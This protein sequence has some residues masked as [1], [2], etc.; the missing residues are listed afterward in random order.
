LGYTSGHNTISSTGLAPTTAW[1]SNQF[2][3]DAL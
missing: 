2:D 3:Y 1:L